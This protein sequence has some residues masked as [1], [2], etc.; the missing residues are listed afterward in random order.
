MEAFRSEEDQDAKSEPE[1]Q[2]LKKI[3]ELSWPRLFPELSELSWEKNLLSWAGSSS[4]NAEL[5]WA[6][7]LSSLETIFFEA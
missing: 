1:L 3:A 7:E 2:I 4:E 5:S 6:A